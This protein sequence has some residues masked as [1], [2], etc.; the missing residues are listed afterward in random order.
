MAETYTIRMTRGDT[1]EG[2]VRWKDAAGAVITV[3]AARFQI[4]TAANATSTM[5][6][7]SV[8]SGLT[9][10]GDGYVVIAITKTQSAALSSGVYDLELTSD[11]GVVRTVIAGP[12]V[13]DKDV[14]R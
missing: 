13:V 5:L 10:D 6:S 14:S 1:Y 8:G 4:R 9:V 12:F 7:L 3:S 2:K 11:T